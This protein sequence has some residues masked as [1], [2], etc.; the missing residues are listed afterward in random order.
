MIGFAALLAYMSQCEKVN[1][2]Y[3][4]SLSLVFLKVPKTLWEDSRNVSDQGGTRQAAVQNLNVL[5]WSCELRLEHANNGPQLYVTALLCLCVFEW[6]SVFDAAHPEAVP[7]HDIE[8]ADWQVAKGENKED[9]HQHACGLAPGSDLFDLST[10]STGPDPHGLAQRWAGSRALHGPPVPLQH[11]CASR[12]LLMKYVH[13]SGTIR[14]AR[15]IICS[16]F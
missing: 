2:A 4:V 9:H 1:H 12:N 13:T 10:N 15:M 11:W 7:F 14:A 6:L 5:F 8:H 16:L 3:T